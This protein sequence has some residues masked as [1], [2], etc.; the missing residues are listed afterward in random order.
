VL[1]PEKRQCAGFVRPLLV[2]PRRDT[3]GHHCCIAQAN[4]QSGDRPSVLPQV[5]RTGR[6]ERSSADAR[7]SRSTL[8]GGF[9]RRLRL[10]QT[11]DRL[12]PLLPEVGSELV[13]RLAR[14]D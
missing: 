5:V 14:G 3:L 6:L 2:F 7:K 9:S 11:R 4:Q 1:L 10:T 8:Q 12:R 13:E